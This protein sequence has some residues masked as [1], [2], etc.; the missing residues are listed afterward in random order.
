MR[1]ALLIGINYKTDSVNRLKGCIND[2][3]EMNDILTKKYGYDSSDNIILRD[4]SEDPRRIPTRRNIINEIEN[5]VNQSKDLTE[6]WIHYSGHGIWTNNHTDTPDDDAEYIVPSDYMSQ[7]FI[8]DANLLNQIKNVQCPIIVTLD[9]CHSGSML[10]LPWSFEYNDTHNT[11]SFY[12]RTCTRKMNPSNLSNPNIFLISGSEEDETSADSYSI[13]MKES[14]GAFTSALIHCL[15]ETDTS[16]SLINLYKHICS[17]LKKDGYKQKP[18]LSSSN[19]I[20]KYNI[21]SNDTI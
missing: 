2:V 15:K 11:Y 5:L 17:I 4:D 8:Q 6:I 14:M 1:K 18:V 16:I 7:G 13:E 9:C 3:V 12:T 10:D 20:P 21:L 19:V